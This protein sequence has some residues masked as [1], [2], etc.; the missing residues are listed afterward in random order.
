MALRYTYIPA[1]PEG[2]KAPLIVKNEGTGAFC[3]SLCVS[4]QLGG[5]QAK[6]FPRR[7][8]KANPLKSPLK[9]T[10]VEDLGYYVGQSERAVLDQLERIYR[11]G[12]LGFCSI[13]KFNLQFHWILELQFLKRTLNISLI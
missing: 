7:S 2:R 9:P 1:R 13:P 6:G 11:Q 8:V 5:G 3:R 4:G 10:T 12:M